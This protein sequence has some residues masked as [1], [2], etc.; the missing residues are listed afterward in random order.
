MPFLVFSDTEFNAAAAVAFDVAADNDKGP[1][2]I[3]V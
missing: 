3:N 2:S 1:H